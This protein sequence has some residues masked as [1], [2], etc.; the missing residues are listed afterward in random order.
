ME[1]TMS[2]LTKE[3]ERIDI[4]AEPDSEECIIAGQTGALKGTRSGES[5]VVGAVDVSVGSRFQ[6]Q[7]TQMLKSNDF[8]DLS[9]HGCEELSSHGCGPVVQGLRS[10][11]ALR[12]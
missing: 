4:I 9:G 6:Y 5:I 1:V 12:G 2:L 8:A 7:C 3:L 10:I 11:A